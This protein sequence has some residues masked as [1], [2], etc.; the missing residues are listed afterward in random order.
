MPDVPDREELIETILD[1]VN[2]GCEHE[3][4]RYPRQTPPDQTDDLVGHMHAS[5]YELGIDVLVRLGRAEIVDGYW[6]R[7]IWKAKD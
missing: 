7:L 4:D 3:R 6:A 2:Q 1:L 5:S